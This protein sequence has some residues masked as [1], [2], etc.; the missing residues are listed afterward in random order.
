MISIFDG[1]GTLT[2]SL[3]T[4]LSMFTLFLSS[5]DANLC[6]QV[7]SIFDGEGML[8]SEVLEIA[9]DT[10]DTLHH[11]PNPVQLSA[12]SGMYAHSTSYIMKCPRLLM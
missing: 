3:S 7:I 8:T 12:D 4:S 6:L 5:S 11:T 10:L 9:A 2:L 1:E